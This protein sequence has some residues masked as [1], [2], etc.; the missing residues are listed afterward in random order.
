VTKEDRQPGPTPRTPAFDGAFRDAQLLRDLG[1]GVAMH[2]EQNDR[3]PL[4][5]RKLRQCGPHLVRR[6]PVGV[7][8]CWFVSTVGVRQTDNGTSL[9]A[10]GP[11]QT[12][13]DDDAVQPRRD[14]GV[15]PE[16]ACRAVGGEERVLQGVGGLLAV[17]ESPDGDGP[18]PVTVSAEQLTEGVAIAGGVGAQQPR[19]VDIH[20]RAG[21]GQQSI[22]R[23]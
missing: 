3:D 2:V 12:G 10:S 13:V 19:V 17:G 21:H 8:D 5:C 7:E 18:Q 6:V 16:T 20:P 22:V 14:G 11:I 15:A 9:S 4:L 23:W 1:D